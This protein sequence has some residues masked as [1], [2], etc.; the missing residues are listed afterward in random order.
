MR[1]AGLV[2]CLMLAATMPAEVAVVHDSVTGGEIDSAVLRNILLGRTTV[3]ANGVPVVV[4]LSREDGSSID[5]VSGRDLNRLLRGWKR[6]AFSGGGRMPTVV[7]DRAAALRAVAATRG[8]VAVLDLPA[9]V[10]VPAGVQRV[11]LQP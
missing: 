1:V 10:P 11:D 5:E 6:L 4:V 9:G 2:A 8:A 7:D 3:W